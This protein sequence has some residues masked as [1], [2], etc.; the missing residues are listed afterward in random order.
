[1]SP[2]RWV[3]VLVFF[4]VFLSAPVQ[5]Q[6]ATG[7]AEL[8]PSPVDSLTRVNSAS[9]VFDKNLNT[10]N[11]I[12]RLVMDTVVASTRI[13]LAA[14]YLSNIIQIDGAPGGAPRSSES[15]QQT[16]RLSLAHPID[17]PIG[18]R[19]QW[20]SLVYS[21]N[22]GI[23]LNNASNH[24]ILA[25]IDYTPWTS[26]SLTP[27][28]GFRWD[29]QGSIHDRGLVLDV[30]ASLHDID[31]DGYRILGDG[32]FR[33]DR[34]DPRFLENHSAHTSI[35][36]SFGPQSSDSLSFGFYRSRREF[37]LNGDSVIESRT[38]QVF[39]FANLL[40]YDITPSLGANV[41]VG[42]QNR[43]LDKDE[44]RIIVFPVSSTS[45]DTRVEEF[46]L[47]AYMQAWYRSPDASTS[48]HLRFAYSERSE[49]H[50]AKSPDVIT[51]T[52]AVLFAE[53]NR[54]EQSKDNIARRVSLA[55]GISLPVSSSDRIH[56]SG[57]ATVLR[58]DTPSELNLEDRDELLIALTAGTLHRVTRHFHVGITF[59]ATI[60]HLVYLLGERSANNNI[61][62]V[63]RLTPRTVYSPVPWFYTQNAF[64]VLANYTVYD[65]EKQVALARSFSYRQFS[66]MDSTRI[67]LGQRIGLDFFAYLKLY[68]RGMLKWDE[69][70]ERTENSTTDRTMAFQVR[71]SPSRTTIFALGIRYFSQ[72]R[73]L[74]EDSVRKL[75]T[76]FSSV[77]PTCLLQWEVGPHS[78]L[79][80]RG[81]YER[82][83]HSDGT[84]RSTA[85]MTANVYLHF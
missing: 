71:F 47:D 78:F 41:F 30:G 34:L 52:L 18:L 72:S 59:D 3:M 68:E 61:N 49:T 35:E 1:M 43:G 70:L 23:G 65:Y 69:F 26:L 64:E 15:T 56:F 20:S 66:W 37:Y 67:E 17:A 39:T 83:K 79:S 63:I 50:R 4:R 14:N 76:F 13:G 11:W 31:V 77:G 16:F 19:T 42:I 21:D 40:S 81:W 80:F 82:R 8:V 84:S 36:K 75:D 12:G 60:S 53:R 33:Q 85:S 25:G 51:P 27:L 5:A 57:S 32:R 55:G 44:R 73:Y 28:A 45:F 62:R 2:A 29:R 48:A 46:R 22:R 24:T 74:F 7:E 6:E 38:D 58:Y 54:R 9:V 10:F